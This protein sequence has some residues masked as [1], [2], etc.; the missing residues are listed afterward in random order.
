LFSINITMI[1]CY[2]T[3]LQSRAP[4][5][6]IPVKCLRKTEKRHLKIYPRAKAIIYVEGSKLP[7]C[8][9]FSQISSPSRLTV[10]FN[11]KCPAVEP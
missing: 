5:L 3:C 6:T 9:W 10:T 7:S 8:S 11:Y 4:I 1:A 2:N